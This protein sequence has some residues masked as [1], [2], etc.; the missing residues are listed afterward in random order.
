[1]RFGGTVTGEV[2]APQIAG[3]EREPWHKRISLWLLAYRLALAA[4]VV[5]GL[6]FR[7]RRYFVDPLGLWMDEAMWGL[8]L[9]TRPLTQLEFRPIGY[10]AL[11]KLVVHIYS[12]ERTLRCLSYVAGV[13]SLF[14]SIDLAK[15]LFKSRWVRLLCVA[16]IAYQP[17]LIDMTREFKPYAVEFFVHWG[18]V[19]LFVRWRARGSRASLIALLTCAVLAFPLAYNVVFLLPGLF[20][21]LGLSLLRARAYHALTATVLAA[22]LA[23]TL[24]AA[25]YVAAL[26]G[27]T[28]DG[29]GTA[30]FWGK[31]YDVFYL[32][33]AGHAPLARARWIAQKYADLASLPG[34]HGNRRPQT[35]DVV[36]E[37][38]RALGDV[39]EKAWLALHVLGLVALLR[40]RREQLLLLGGPLLVS[41]AFNA[42]HLWP[43]GAFRT[44][45]FLL[46]YLVLI[47]LLG[48]DALLAARSAFMRGVGVFGAGLL[49]VASLS[50]GFEPHTRKHFFS[51]QTEMASLVARMMTIRAQLPSEQRT[52]RTLAYFDNT[53]CTP[54]IFEA[55]YNDTIKRA[56]GSLE[57]AIDIHCVSTPSATENLLRR[58]TGQNFF[59]VIGDDRRMSVYQRL[60]PRDAKVVVSESIRG[61]E[62]LYFARAYRGRAR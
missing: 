5:V 3:R 58:I 31:K 62:D 24:I 42:C 22:V 15:Q 10:M 30:Q 54:F 45:V 1:M 60:L 28:Q 43:F 33:T 36:I 38:A 29:D 8:R 51:T 56:Y 47:P 25:I 35:A 2:G 18:L 4:L 12:D 9:F 46:A 23:L 13:G 39:S 41:I 49:L 6:Y 7:S 16:V 40:Y 32:P 20:A 61:V 34:S 55:R 27:T 11:T 48:L 17:L 59:L 21:L 26:R 14:I 37:R 44:N 19:W 52:G 50:T 57:Q 53:T